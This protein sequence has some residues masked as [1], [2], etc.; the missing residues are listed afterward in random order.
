MARKNRNVAE[1]DATRCWGR[2]FA[3][4]VTQDANVAVGCYLGGIEFPKLI[5]S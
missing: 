1:T 5:W 4:R 3:E 2:H